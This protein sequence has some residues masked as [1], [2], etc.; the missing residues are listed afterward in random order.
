MCKDGVSTAQLQMALEMAEQQTALASGWA[1][2]IAHLAGHANLAV[3]EIAEAEA[4]LKSAR[5]SLEDAVDAVKA[6]AA[7][8]GSFEVTAV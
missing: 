1:K 4:A 7:T 6:G 5:R 3:A 2:E 8:S